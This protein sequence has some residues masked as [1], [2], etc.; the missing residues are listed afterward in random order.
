[1]AFTLV[2]L[3][4]VVV[5]SIYMHVILTAAE[6]LLWTLLLLIYCWLDSSLLCQYAE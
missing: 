3:R 1:M 2:A 5:G 4:F 6:W